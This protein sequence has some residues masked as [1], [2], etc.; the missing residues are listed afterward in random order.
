MRAVTQIITILLSVA[1]LGLAGWMAV[2][3]PQPHL[4]TMTQFEEVAAPAAPATTTPEITTP[5][6]T[7]PAPTANTSLPEDIRIIPVTSGGP[8]AFVTG[9]L[10]LNPDRAE[11]NDTVEVS[12]LVRN[13]GGQT[14]TYKVELKLRGKSYETKDVTL[15]SGE[16]QIV[17][18]EYIPP[19]EGE[20]KFTVDELFIALFVI[21]L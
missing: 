15:G 4:A 3:P 20:Y 9:E 17:V 19:I 14:G 18:F 11:P 10:S 5:E 13:I 1:L 8:A 7:T 6:I 2:S 16:S 21:H 12:V